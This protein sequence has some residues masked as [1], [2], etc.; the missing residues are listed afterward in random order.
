MSEPSPSLSET[1]ARIDGLCRTLRRSRAEVLNAVDLSRRTG[2]TPTV[3]ELLLVGGSVDTPEEEAMVRDRVVFLFETRSG[4]DLNKVSAIARQIGATPTWTKKLVLGQAKPSL[5]AGAKL[6]RYYGVDSDFLTDSPEDA[7]KRELRKTLFDL[8]V[9]ADPG[10]ALQEMGV[11]HVTRRSSLGDPNLAALAR[12]VA[13]IVKDELR[14]VK[15][16]MDRLESLEGD[17]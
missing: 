4:G 14:P 9:E 2:L 10:K 6:C 16:R 5:I 12:M 15:E 13:S 1:L 17:G 3:V 8:E 11:S 7:L